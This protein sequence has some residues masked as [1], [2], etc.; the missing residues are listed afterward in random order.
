MQTGR[1]PRTIPQW[2]VQTAESL[3][4]S[5]V[6]HGRRD[7]PLVC[8]RAA[9][10]R[11]LAELPGH[12]QRPPRTKRSLA[13]RLELLTEEPDGGS[14]AHETKSERFNHNHTQQQYLFNFK[15]K[16]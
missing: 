9:H 4:Q 15:E 12:I 14:G 16:L 7:V 1:R 2:I 10:I 5:N 6:A 8:P 13:P 11:T 3:R